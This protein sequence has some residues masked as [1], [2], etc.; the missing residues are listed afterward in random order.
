M[1]EGVD[2]NRRIDRQL[3]E[4][5]GRRR[6]MFLNLFFYWLML[7]ASDLFFVL[8]LIDHLV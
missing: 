4:P 3:L 7:K 2:K 5:L 8:S 6:A 1:G